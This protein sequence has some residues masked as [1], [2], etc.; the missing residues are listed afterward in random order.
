MIQGYVDAFLRPSIRGW[1][2]DT[3]ELGRSVEVEVVVDGKV[4]VRAT[5]DQ[6]RADL[7]RSNLGS[8]AFEV[9]LD[10]DSWPE[11]AQVVL[12]R[13]VGS[14][15]ALAN[16]I[17]STV[18]PA[19]IRREDRSAYPEMLRNISSFT[20]ASR[21]EAY[22]KAVGDHSHGTVTSLVLQAIERLAPRELQASAETGC[23]KTTVLLSNMS[24]SHLAFAV[25]DSAGEGSSV[26]FCQ[27]CPLF[28]RDRTSIVSGPTQLT[29]PRFELPATLDFVLLDGPHGYPFPD[30]EYF[31][32][33][34]RLREGS[35][36]VVDDIHIPTV[37]NLFRFLSD[38]EMFDLVEVVDHTAFF[39][40][41]AALTFPPHGDGWW[42]QRY[43]AAR[44][45]VTVEPQSPEEAGV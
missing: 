9:S 7:S 20:M 30:L 40:R 32:F 26:R 10:P 6:E 13:P 2:R 3:A 14:V 34:P 24:S 15:A 45:P 25:D 31:Y 29:L 27:E 4:V 41:S 21:I 39:R 19:E 12:V 36:L 35:I 8:C 42:L 18:T 28:R 33:Y 16:G 1:A 43:N 23:G 17:H 11:G 44:F 37:H 5:C 38:E 22:A